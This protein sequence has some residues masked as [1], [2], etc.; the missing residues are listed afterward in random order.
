[1]FFLLL[2][3]L[4]DADGVYSHNSRIGII[5]Q[6]K[7]RCVEILCDVQNMILINGDRPAIL[8]ASPKM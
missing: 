5:A 1:M 7:K 4:V 3:I 8:L 6:M 2:I